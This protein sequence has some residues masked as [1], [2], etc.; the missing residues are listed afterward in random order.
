MEKK[1]KGGKQ[2]AQQG[3]VHPET[4][5]PVRQGVA[6]ANSSK[7]HIGGQPD[8]RS[9]HDKDGNGGVAGSRQERR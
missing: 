1:V 9:N 5:A 6:D 4:Q 2:P 8:A 3:T 7:T